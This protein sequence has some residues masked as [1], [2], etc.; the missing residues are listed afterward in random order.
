[1]TSIRRSLAAA[2][3]AALAAGALTVVGAGTATAKS[4]RV[5]E[6]KDCN[7]IA[8]KLKLSPED[9]RMEVEYELDQNRT[10]RTWALRLV[11]NGSKVAA[12]RR[13]TRGPSG[14]LTWR[15]VVDDTAGTETITVR[16]KGSGRTCRITAAM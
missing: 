3:A 6:T 12:A 2:T 13:T 14:S 1:M 11:Q 10:G 7:G 8:T 16:A 5:I 9:G 15:V 4:P